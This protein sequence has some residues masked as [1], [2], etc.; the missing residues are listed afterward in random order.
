MQVC[1]QMGLS[2]PTGGA[3][4][5]AAYPYTADLLALEACQPPPGGQ[6]TPSPME[7]TPLDADTWEAMLSSHP[8][9]V[10]AQ[11]IVRGLRHGFR[12]GFNRSHQLQS[13]TRNMFSALQHT[14]IV[15]EYIRKEVDL[16]RIADTSHTGHTH[17]NRFGV[18]PKGHTPG[19]WRLIT[20]LSFPEGGSVNDGIDPA[21][22]S[23]SY[24][25]VETVAAAAMRWGR[26]AMMAK[27]DIESAYRL[28]PVHPDDQPLLGVRW[29]ESVYRD[30][31]LPFGLRS[32][33]KIFSAIADALEWCVRQND[34]QSVYHYLDDFIVLGRPG[35]DECGRSLEQ[36]SRT[37]TE[38][39]VPLAAHKT[40]GPTTCITFLGIEIDSVAGELRLP[41]AKLQRVQEL[42]REW[43]DRKAC[44]RRELESLIGTLNHACKVV[45]PGRSFLRN[46]INLLHMQGRASRKPHHHIRLNRPFRADLAWWRTFAQSWN[47]VAAVTNW[48]AQAGPEFASDASGTW[49]CGAWYCRQWFQLQWEGPSANLPIAV[50]EMIP[51]IIASVAWGRQWR[52]QQVTCH[53]D[54][55]AVVAV[56]SSRTSKHD[57][58]MHL[59]RCLFFIEARF[60]FELRCM[61]VAGIKNDL[62]DDLSRNNL[63]SFRSKV[64]MA[65]EHPTPIPYPLL[66]I[67]MDPHLDWISPTWTRQFNTIMNTV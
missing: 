7:Q 49:G 2:L 39:R 30:R 67:M 32:A 13:A 36:L 3:K 65:D 14:S 24:V 1:M 50:K 12:I 55:M 42:L 37:C 16:H 64:A 35:T 20:D 21:H 58:L 43:G 34:V 60:N 23:L 26:G 19:K 8:D 53:C 54:N 10:F 15:T 31:M 18:I 47:G 29:R 9:R 11:F 56:L 45:R 52:G 61:H 41:P 33:P 38:L 57:H 48:T 63:S 22:C 28:V 44:T 17:I 46:M 25:S 59:A 27:V 66:S 62:A 6:H 5:S 4:Q 40:E 51:I